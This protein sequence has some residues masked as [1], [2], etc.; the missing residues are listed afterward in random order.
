MTLASQVSALQRTHPMGHGY[1]P[2]LFDGRDHQFKFRAPPKRAVPINPRPDVRATMPGI[3]N[4]GMHGSCVLHAVGARFMQIAKEQIL[5]GNWSKSRLWTPSFAQ[6][7]Y[8]VRAM[9][10]TLAL[11][12]GCMPKNAIVVASQSKARGKGIAP[13]K[14]HPYLSDAPE[15]VADPHTWL[16]P[17]TSRALQK[18][19]DQCY[20][21]AR[22]HQITEY[23]RVENA[24]TIGEIMQCLSEGRAVPM[25]FTC[26]RNSLYDASGMPRPVIT[27]PTRYDYSVGGHMVIT[28]AA[29]DTPDDWDLGGGIVVP[30]HHL[31]MQNSWTEHVQMRGYFAMPFDY[32]TNANLAGDFWDVLGSEE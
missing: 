27:V 30:K 5:A 7:Y 11:D 18:P 16:Y 24:G 3:M 10:G 25:G 31:L 8:D 4:Q 13:A 6:M 12:N 2:D 29:N 21:S 32:A 26:Y 9:E 17:A 20:R 15:D 14:Y 23:R 19:S 22:R 28:V 1:I